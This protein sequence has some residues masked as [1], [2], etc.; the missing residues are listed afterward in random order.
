MYSLYGYSPNDALFTFGAEIIHCRLKAR[1]SLHLFHFVDFRIN[2]LPDICPEFL[3]PLVEGRKVVIICD[4]ALIPLALFYIRHHRNVVAVYSIRT[5]PDV[6]IQSLLRWEAGEQILR[7]RAPRFE[8]LTKTEADVI[9]R[10]GCQ[11]SGDIPAEYSTTKSLYTHER[12][13][14]RKFGRRRFPEI[15]G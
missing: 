3:L 2:N 7:I 12:N 15:F 10:Y 14:A 5:A 1:G 9:G 11:A 4:D 13:I 8:I 6:I